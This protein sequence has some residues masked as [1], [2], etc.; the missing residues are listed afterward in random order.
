MD[1]DS[2]CLAST[3]FVCVF[4]CFVFLRHAYLPSR[5]LSVAPALPSADHWL[6][7]DLNVSTRV[8]RPLV[9]LPRLTSWR[10]HGV[11]NEICFLCIPDQLNC[12]FG[13]K[14]RIALCYL[15]LT[16]VR[17]MLRLLHLRR[18]LFSNTTRLRP[19]LGFRMNKRVKLKQTASRNVLLRANK[20]GG[21]ELQW[22]LEVFEQ[23]N[24]QRHVGVWDRK[25]L[26]VIVHK[27]KHWQYESLSQNTTRFQVHFRN[28]NMVIGHCVLPGRC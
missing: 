1:K 25:V 28:H 11:D 15:T 14:S 19:A 23:L 6:T 18:F 16:V 2:S 20:M 8:Q 4:R 26:A 7:I 5:L 9:V 12:F 13:D 24:I 22:S 21:C 3:T 27:V 10:L 17:L